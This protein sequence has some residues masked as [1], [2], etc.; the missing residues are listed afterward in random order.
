VT[1]IENDDEL[2]S[3]YPTQWAAQKLAELIAALSRS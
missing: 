3:E 2:R 1:H